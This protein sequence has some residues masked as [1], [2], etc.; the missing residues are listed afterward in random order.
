MNVNEF[1][2]GVAVRE[3]WLH[4]VNIRPCLSVSYCLSTQFDLPFVFSNRLTK[5]P[6]RGGGR[7]EGGKVKEGWQVREM[8]YHPFSHC[9]NCPV[10]KAHYGPM[11]YKRRPIKTS[12]RIFQLNNPTLLDYSSTHIVLQSEI[13]EVQPGFFSLCCCLQTAGI[14]SH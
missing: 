2:T 13:Q 5:S 8:G 1:A 4:R 3:V 11:N 14:V 7:G 10:I 12:L 9:L 6:R